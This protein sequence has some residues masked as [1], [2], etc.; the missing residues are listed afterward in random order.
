M[1]TVHRAERADALLGPLGELL[2]TAAGDVLEPEIIAVPTRGVERWLAQQLALTLG[3]GGAGDGVAAN[4]EFPSPTALIDDVLATIA[5]RD[6]ATDPWLRDRLV[7][8]VL[9]VLDES[10]GQPWCAIIDH[11]LGA[12]RPPGSYRHGRRF[13][14]A[15][16]IARLFTSYADNRPSMLVDWAHARDTDGA[17]NELAPDARW[18]PMLW[19]RLRERLDTPSPAE[20]LVDSCERLA[21]D[22][23]LVGLPARLS[24]FGLTRLS[25]TALAVVQALAQGREVHLW[26]THPSPAL[27]STVD[28]APPAW[29]RRDDNTALL[30]TNPLLASLARDVRELQQRLPP[31]YVDIHH[32]PVAAPGRSVLATLQDDV[33]NN[34]APG[35]DW[36]RDR[37]DSLQAY[38]CHG[39][40]RQVEVLRESLLHLFNND[41]SL[42]PRDVLIMCPDVDAFA[43]LLAAAFSAVDAPHP[44]HQLRVR[45]ADRSPAR[46][47]PLLEIAG[48]LLDLAGERIT[49]TQV[50]DL[51][52][53][54]PVARKFGFAAD[55]LDTLRHWSVQA[56]ARWGLTQDQREAFGVG[57]VTQN[58]FAHA[59]DRILLGVAAADTGADWL[60]DAVPLGE[61]ASSDVEL[62]GR[63]AEYLERL[64]A[65]VA[66]L[67][68]PHT[69]SGWVAV[70]FDALDDLAEAG[71]AQAWQRSDAGRR[72]TAALREAGDTALMVSDVRDALAKAVRPRATRTNF[73]TG[74][75]TVA[76]LM[77]MRFVPHR[78]VAIVGLDD[79]AFPRAGQLSGDDIL[80][81]DPW[82]GER[83]PRSEDRQLFLDAIMAA[84]DHL[85]LCYT[86]ADPVTGAHKPP[87]APLADL[88]D[89]AAA[90]VGAPVVSRQPLQPF[91]SANFVAPQPFSFDRQACAAAVAARTEHRPRPAFL[92]APLDPMAGGDE[93][94]LTDLVTFIVDPTT[95]FLA[96]RLGVRLPRTA[97]G[98]AD[99]LPVAVDGLAMWAIGDRML[100]SALTAAMGG[101]DLEARIA[102]IVAA[103]LR[104]GTLP[105]GQTGADLAAD[106][107]GA[108]GVIARVA[109]RDTAG[110][111][112][113]T[114]DIDCAVGRYR[115]VGTVA[116]V[117][118]R[119]IVTARYAV[120][121]AKHRLASW[122]RLLALA[123]SDGRGDWRA[124]TIGRL[125]DDIGLAKRSVLKLPADPAEVLEDLLELRSLGLGAPLP[126]ATETSHVYACARREGRTVAQARAE[127][128]AA[129]TSTGGAGYRNSCEN[130]DPAIVCVY[131]PDAPFSALWDQPVPDGQPRNADE[132]SWFGQLAVRLWAPLLRRESMMGA[133]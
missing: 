116:D 57:A 87:V 75:I 12:G 90:T 82:V 103:E 121:G 31:G 118:G 71:E 77:P 11:H 101:D 43:P 27:W 50:L 93:V 124:L 10:S 100:Q 83:D 26:L 130:D 47:N 13:S 129:W 66:V 109:G 92:P 7:G 54:E 29:Q 65:A 16:Q 80:A 61:V 55:E 122:V 70:L 104:R 8:S 30:A 88:L 37:D 1:L 38:A 120:L 34:V 46:I 107:A 44:G 81:A 19:R 123:C 59:C 35:Q 98:V 94:D 21:A 45:L 9:S 23:G 102:A 4:I 132:P 78:V 53:R 5:G 79:G 63:F 72:I 74:E 64:Q 85:L 15:T 36:P 106:I 86:G 110:Y 42:Q 3:A 99:E 67:G 125:R 112:S 119:R 41:A 6:A 117:F 97:R 40:A 60:G 95:A 89:T 20:R 84:T 2:L 128:V 22:P 108:A 32:R 73:R 24:V 25:H 114:V 17:G 68:G 91:D 33:R 69:G 56:G 14:T 105:P 113:D 39:Q 49:A 133:K 131:G 111:P 28:A 96:Q 127:A 126:T 48:V 76:A 18:Q 115:L 52:A 51:A 62:A 58:T